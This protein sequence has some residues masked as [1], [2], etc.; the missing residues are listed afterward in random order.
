VRYLIVITAPGRR[1]S[2][3]SFATESAFV[4]HLQAMKKELGPRFD[5]M[6]VAMPFLSDAQYQQRR[7]QM[8]V[9]DEVKERIRFE[10]LYPVDPSGPTFLRWLP[11]M[12]LKLSRLVREAD[13]VHSHPDYDLWRPWM[14]IASLLAVAMRKKLIAITDMDNRRDA[15]MNLQL[16]RWSTKSYLICRY[17]YDPIR[18][19]QQRAYV[20]AAD[21]ML[22]KEPQQVEDY[23]R[24]APHVR[25]F[26]DPNFHL[27]QIASEERIATKVR[28]LSDP[29]V[30]LRLLY[31]GRLVTYKGIDKMIEAVAIARRRG[32][33]LTFHIMGAGEDEGRLRGLVEQHGIGDLVAWIEP[34]PYGEAF[35]AELRVRDL[36][37]ACPLCADTPRS[38]WDAIASGMPVLAFDTPFYRGMGEYTGAV[39]VV[40]WPDVEQLASRLVEV[41]AHKE[42]LIPQVRRAVLAA[43][44]NTGDEW[45][46]RRVAWVEELFGSDLR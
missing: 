2:P 41:A 38:T 42:R 25:M 4:D 22:Y 23:G 36:L 16:G 20:K 28:E 8:S 15:A 1:L 10:P 21:L 6:V 45:L 46:R 24:G 5:E 31:F 33:R 19:I 27:P 11:S 39:E 3:T 37:L 34:K 32:A 7:S 13:L 29:T 43:H 26:L 14:G 18:D 12:A 30:P 17:V 44:D 9:L 35:F 40:P